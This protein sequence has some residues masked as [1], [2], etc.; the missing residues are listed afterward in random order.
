MA[1]SEK[2]TNHEQLEQTIYDVQLQ[3]DN[4]KKLIDYAT[5]ILDNAK[6]TKEELNAQININT[7]LEE[8]QKQMKDQ[9]L[10]MKEDWKREQALVL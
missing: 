1:D 8:N 7:I 10:S 4:F 3:E 6:K 2:K 5:F 9:V